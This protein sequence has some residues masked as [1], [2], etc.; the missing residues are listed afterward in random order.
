MIE[1]KN[2]VDFLGRRS[3][4]FLT[5][6]TKNPLLLLMLTYRG[7]VLIHLSQY[8]ATFKIAYLTHGTYKHYSWQY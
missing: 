4:I 2:V 5:G 7:I 1:E 3:T 8:L 6:K